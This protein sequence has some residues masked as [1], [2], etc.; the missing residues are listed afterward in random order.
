MTPQDIATD[1][2]ECKIPET[3]GQQIVMGTQ[4]FVG[5]RWTIDDWH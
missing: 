4:S 5:N 1:I 2:A 3:A